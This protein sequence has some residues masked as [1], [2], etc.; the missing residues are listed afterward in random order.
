MVAKPKKNFIKG[1]IKRPG[2]FTAWAK[3]K[4]FKGVTSGAI[5]AGIKA[6]GRVAKEAILARTL[7]RIARKRK[8]K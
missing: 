3:R 4:G 1:A 2:A 8:G 5:A 6:G 7:Q